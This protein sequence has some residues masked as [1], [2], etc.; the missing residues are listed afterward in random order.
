M[1]TGLIRGLK[2]GELCCDC[3]DRNKLW[4][5][6]PGEAANEDITAAIAA[7]EETEIGLLINYSGNG[8]PKQLKSSTSRELAYNLEH[9]VHYEALIK[10]GLRELGKLHLVD[11]TFGVA[12]SRL[13]Y[14]HALNN[15]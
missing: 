13:K 12:P 1:Y 4:E 11:E 3:R 15:T 2:N 7:M 10:V 9:A 6:I 5:T 8:A 14:R